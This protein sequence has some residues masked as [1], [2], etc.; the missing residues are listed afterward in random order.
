MLHAPWDD[1]PSMGYIKNRPRKG[2]TVER[3]GLGERRKKQGFLQ[4]L[5]LQPPPTYHMHLSGAQAFLAFL[6]GPVPPLFPP[7]LAPVWWASTPKGVPA[8][9]PRP[10]GCL[11]GYSSPFFRLF[12]THFFLFLIY[13]HATKQG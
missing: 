11:L 3:V 10:F 12:V 8:P 1:F 5:Y 7:V 9:P 13:K 4:F 6:P 2:T